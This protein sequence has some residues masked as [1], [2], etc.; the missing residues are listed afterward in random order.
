MDVIGLRKTL[1]LVLIIVLYSQMILFQNVFADDIS[2][3][4]ELFVPVFS[5]SENCSV[6]I[7]KID[8]SAAIV[9]DSKS[10]RI[11]FEK[12]AH[13]R[14]PM[15]STTKIMT[16][17]IA[18][19]KGDLNS[20]VKVSK[21]SAAIGGSTAHLKEGQ[22][23]T[24]NDMLYGLMLNSGNDAAIAI[25]EHIGG[26]VEN[27]LLMMN[28]KAD[29]LGAKNTQF[30]SPHGLD[31]EGHY[32]TA[33]DLA[34]IT[35]YA[36]QNPVF[37]KIVGTKEANISSSKLR[38]TN[39]MLDVYPGADGVKTGYTGLAGRCLVTSAT[40]EGRRFIS[41]VLNCPTRQKRAQNSKGIL[42]YSF[43]NYKSHTLLKTGESMAMIPVV[44]GIQKFVDVKAVEDIVFPL[45]ED[46]TE[47]IETRITLPDSLN[48][49]VYAGM[50]VGYIEF[51]LNGEIIAY[52]PLKTWTDIR[53]KC[54]GDYINEIFNA[55]IRMMQ[56]GVLMQ[57]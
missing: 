25:A 16:A 10:G 36:L 29:Q 31:K 23:L 19:E 42:D 7:P 12:N 40:R 24:L 43:T 2:E 48:A 46:E 49:P 51:V 13:S 26:T 1:A 38:N 50:D 14:K 41:V 37:S 44:K 57:F 5:N 52:S 54:F 9:M 17:I 6:Q 56:E 22:T 39:E 55:W 28:K 45:R 30:Q 27:F 33:Y 21:R 3:V 18:I 35:R 11:L 15:A 34:L 8:A 32:S 20:Q 4:D 53:H 47:I